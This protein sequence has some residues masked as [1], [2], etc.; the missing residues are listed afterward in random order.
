M[1]V[2][3]VVPTKQRPHCGKKAVHNGIELF[4]VRGGHPADLYPVQVVQVAVII[5]GGSGHMAAFAIINGDLVAPLYH[6][7]GQGFYHNLNAALSGGN[8]LV[9][10]H[11]DFHGR[12]PYCAP[13]PVNTTPKVLNR[14]LIS[15]LGDQLSMYWQSR[16]TTSSK[17]SIWDRPLTCHSPVM[18]GRM[19]SRRLW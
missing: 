13:W 11:C 14:I 15:R 9:T 17:S 5:K 18:P 3:D 7:A 1:E 6:T 4:A 10:D 12:P 16:R 8:A 2:N 19:D